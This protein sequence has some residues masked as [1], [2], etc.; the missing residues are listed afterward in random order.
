MLSNRMTM[1]SS[2]NFDNGILTFYTNWANTDGSF[3][4]PI[5]VK[6]G[7]P[8]WCDFGDGTT[9]ALTGTIAHS[10]AD[11]STKTL[12]VWP[13]DGWLGLTEFYVDSKKFINGFPDFKSCRNLTFLNASGNQL[14][15][16]IPSFSSCP[17]L[18]MFRAADNLF[19]GS[20]PSFNNCTLLQDF[21]ING[22]QLTGTFPSFSNCTVL[23]EFMFYDNL[24]SGTIPDFSGCISLQFILGLRNTFTGYT[25]GSFATQPNINNLRFDGNNLDQTSVDNILADLV[26]SLGISGRV[27]C[28]VQLEGGTN[29][30][31][32]SVTNKNTLI[33]AGW[34]VTTN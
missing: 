22:N 34:S 16:N 13:V 31:P 23:R 32:S 8:L 12:K 7:T 20:L 27:S 33:S 26:T 2:N 28:N 11:A 15:G 4:G 29:S 19:S 6:S 25:A 10:Y 5:V 18:I 14:D 17:S 1:A 24:F 30:A 21:R 9:L 3:S